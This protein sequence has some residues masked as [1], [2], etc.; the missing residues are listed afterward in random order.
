MNYD[1]IVIGSGISGACIARELSKYKLHTA[2]LEKGSDLCSGATKG[3]S[4]TVHSGHD[5]AYGTKKAYYNVKGNAL[6][7][8]LCEELSVPFFRNGTYVIGITDNDWKKLEELKENADKNQ[9]PDVQLLTANEL[10]QRDTNWSPDVK[11]ALYA[12]T[13]GV[14]CPYTLTF[15]LCENAAHNGTDFYL[16]TEVLTI[17]KNSDMFHLKTNK[18]EFTAHYIFNCAGVH[19]DEMNNFVSRHTFHIT[20][21]KGSHVILDKKLAPYVTSTL[22]QTPTDLPGG[23]HTKGMGIMPTEGGTIL[24]GCEAYDISD[25]DDT[26]AD[27]RGLQEI[28]NYFEKNWKYF[29]ISAVYPSFP[30]NMIISSFSSV[31]PHPD[32]DDFILGE[33]ED[34][35]HFINVSGI[36]SPG[37]TAAPAIAVDLVSQAARQYGWETDPDFDPFRKVPKPFREMTPQEQA[38]AV[39]ENP[40]YGKI[41]CRCEQVTKAEILAAIHGPV[42]ARTVNAVKMRTR[43]GMGRC[44][45]GFCSPEVVRIL[46]EELHIPMTEVTLSGGD[47]RILVSETC[48]SE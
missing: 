11:G 13:G 35:P 1:V 19:A 6:Y 48:I 27:E 39:R 16:D 9:V 33:A 40:D 42:G 37:V 24:L 8:Q 3:N 28:L 17:E 20:P 30:R 31:R 41:I 32:T 22:C 25:K 29:P 26:A 18:G 43:A 47:S 10:K 34:C 15:A 7:D 2:V 46:S 44:Q 5:A 4:A 14:V 36:E 23:G 38:E 21:R 12:P 45:G